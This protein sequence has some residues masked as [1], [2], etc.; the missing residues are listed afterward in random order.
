MNVIDEFLTGYRREMDDYEQVARITS[1]QVKVQLGSAGI[2]AIITDRAKSLDR[3]AAKV[4]YRDKEK[5]YGS[6]REIQDDIV[7]LAGVRIAL[8]FPKDREEVGRIIS[9]QFDLT[10]APKVFPKKRVKPSYEKR[11]DGY[12]AM[13]YRVKLRPETL[14]E[15]HRRYADSVVEIQVASV[16]MHAWAEVEHDLVY[17]PFQGRLSEEEYA[18]LDELNG[19]VLAGEISLERLQAAMERRLSQDEVVFA[20]HFDLAGYLHSKL[21]EKLG[22]APPEWAIGSVDLLFDLMRELDIA[23]PDKAEELIV[24]LHEHYEKRPVSEQLIDLLLEQDQRRYDVYYKVRQRR[25]NARLYADPMLIEKGTEQE[26]AIGDFMTKW[27]QLE[28]ILRERGKAA[29]GGK[30]SKT[31]KRAIFLGAQ[32]LSQKDAARLGQL[33]HIRNNLVHGIEIPEPPYLRA[34]AKDVE[35]F[36][37]VLGSEDDRK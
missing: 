4:R 25:E 8:Y 30:Q 33:R 32:S 18:I 34:A 20:S 27:I 2:R 35:S 24:D 3:L 37:D 12:R 36:I 31:L 16:L 7:D 5:K 13:H 1:D 10:R 28:M 19:L 29:Q 6:V 11:F 9:S 26:A 22:E 23:H 15:A 17:K 14:Q 21:S